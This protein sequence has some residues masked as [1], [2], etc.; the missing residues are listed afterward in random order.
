MADKTYWKAKLYHGWTYFEGVYLSPE[1]CKE[2]FNILK[3]GKT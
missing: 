3:G 2:L 1:A